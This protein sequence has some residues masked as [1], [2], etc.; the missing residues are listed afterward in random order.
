[1][2]RRMSTLTDTNCI[3]LLL[4]DVQESNHY[5]GVRHSI[6]QQNRKKEEQME[7]REDEEEH[8]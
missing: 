8:V 6:A 7:E 3:R 5:V 4:C 1:M 2:N